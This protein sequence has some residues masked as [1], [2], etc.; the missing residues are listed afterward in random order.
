MEQHGVCCMRTK[1][2]TQ[3]LSVDDRAQL[4][5]RCQLVGF[6]IVHLYQSVNCPAAWCFAFEAVYGGGDDDDGDKLV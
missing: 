3:K 5:H 1:P 6:A 4:A 2:E